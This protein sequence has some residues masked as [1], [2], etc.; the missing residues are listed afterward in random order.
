MYYEDCTGSET[1]PIQLLSHSVGIMLRTKMRVCDS[2]HSGV[3]Q[4]CFDIVFVC[5]HAELKPTLLAHAPVTSLST[6]PTG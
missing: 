6:V 3:S 5:M 1:L 4:D 2:L